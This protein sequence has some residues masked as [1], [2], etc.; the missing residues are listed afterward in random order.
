MPQVIRRPDKG[1]GTGPLIGRLRARVKREVTLPARH[2]L[3]SHERA[4]LAATAARREA[5]ARG[6]ITRR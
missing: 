4:A 6:V 1:G 5:Q 2:P 3:S